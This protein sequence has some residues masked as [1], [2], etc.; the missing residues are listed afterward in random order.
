[1]QLDQGFE[2]YAVER[3]TAAELVDRATRWLDHQSREQPDTPFFLFLNFMDTHRPYKSEPASTRLPQP[4]ADHPG[5]L[6]KKL[7]AAV[8]ESDEPAPPDLTRRVIAHYDASIAN[9]D[10]GVGTLLH[11]L[12]D[13]GLYDN[14]IIAITSDHGEY[15]G[16]HELVE[17]SKDI[18]EAAIRIPL[19]V[20]APGQRFGATDPRIV[21]SVDVARLLLELDPVL[22]GSHIGEFPY[23]PGN[24]PAI[25]ENYYSRGKDLE[26]SYGARFNRVRT[27]VIFDDKRSGSTSNW[28]FIRSSDGRHELY[29]LAVDPAEAHNLIETAPDVAKRGARLLSEFMAGREAPANTAGIA[30]DPDEIEMLEELGYL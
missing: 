2:S 6:L 8:M 16:E 1:M 18:Y 4:S 29:D 9:A 5:R 7:M 15:F 11:W 3:G 21:T 27:A 19:L 20:K 12:D 28:K 23:E 10:E 22:R 13:R 26:K 14:A 25:V 30:I 17:H 24:H